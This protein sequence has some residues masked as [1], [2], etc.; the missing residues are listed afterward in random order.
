[1]VFLPQLL[2]YSNHD[3]WPSW[4]IFFIIPIKRAIWRQVYHMGVPHLWNIRFFYMAADFIMWKLYAPDV[5]INSSSVMYLVKWLKFKIFFPVHVFS[6]PPIIW[7][8]YLFSF[9]P[10]TSWQHH[11][12]SN[13]L[14]NFLTNQAT[15]KWQ[16]G[17]LL[18][19]TVVDTS[20]KHSFISSPEK[21]TATWPTYTW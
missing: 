16:Y 2:I 8:R 14:S 21:T 6:E 9:W 15:R 17:C 10:S 4:W 20:V 13:T 5:S 19:S 1:M 18:Q 12:S 7:Q 3:P 11:R